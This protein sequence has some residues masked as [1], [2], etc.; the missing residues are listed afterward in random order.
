MLKNLQIQN[1]ALIRH[2][3]ITPS[4]GL[5]MITGETG[6]GKSIMIGA[7]GLLLG[8]RVDTRVLY[9]MGEKCIVEGVFNIGEYALQELFESNELDYLKETIVR[10]EISP[11]GKSRAFIN[12]SPVNL[13]IMKELGTHLMD[14]HSQHDTYKLSSLNYQLSLVDVF[15]QNQEKLQHYREAYHEYIKI[16]RRLDDLVEDATSLRKEAD[17]NHFLY[18]ELNAANLQSGEQESLED[19][20]STLEHA[21]EIKNVISEVITMLHNHDYAVL[22]QF[23]LV[24]KKMDSIASF[25]MRLEEIRTRLNSS[26]LEIKDVVTDLENEIDTVEH[27]PEKLAETQSRLN[28]LYKFLQKHQ[29]HTV[30]E[31]LAIQQSLKVKVNKN[32]NLDTDIKD[33]ENETAA[34]FEKVIELGDSL[35]SCRRENFSRIIERIEEMLRSLGIPDAKLKIDHRITEPGEHGV[36]EIDLKFSANKGVIPM[37]LKQVASGGE[38]SRLMFCIKH[39]IASKTA[40]PT[41]ILDEIDTG[42]SGEI[43]IK[44]ATMMKQ[45]AENHQVITITHLPQIASFG[46]THYYVYKDNHS[47]K[48]ISLVKKLTDEERVLEIAKMI[49]GDHPTEA[50][51]KNAKEL[52]GKSYIN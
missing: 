32:L 22:D 35:S 45:M 21:E 33:L 9:D 4:P 5:N 25:A 14:I 52:L 34:R 26:Y 27:D 15:S 13:D 8:N 20:L 19:D 51:F 28:L 46:N 47:E 2:L 7:V 44:M 23:S 24:N 42:I 37:N 6:A 16:K 39:I 10:R 50:A 30:D 36:D 48:S 49:G 29:V 3:E 18:E 1:Y 41:L 11:S 43:A 12:D 38:F 17:Y 31:L 40:L